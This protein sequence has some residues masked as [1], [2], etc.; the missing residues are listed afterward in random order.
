MGVSLLVLGA[1]LIAFSLYV[2]Q[3]VEEG[4]AKVA[5]VQS[6][7]DTGNRFLSHDPI[8][9]RI[10]EEVTGG[11][12]KKIDE[13]QEQIDFYEKVAF[14]TKTGGILSLVLGLGAFFLRQK[15]R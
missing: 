9:K 6:Q 15:K 8:T 1:A 10:G 12:Q 2:N 5:K 7:V 13:G 3:Q 4:K 11:I 14:W